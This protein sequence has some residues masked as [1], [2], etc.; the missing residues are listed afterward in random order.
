MISVV[1]KGDWSF[2]ITMSDEEHEILMG[3]LEREN[4]TLEE[5]LTGFIKWMVEDPER[6][7][8]WYEKKQILVG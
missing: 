4:L 3:V 8:I 6:F 5:L 7:R 1:D 2:E